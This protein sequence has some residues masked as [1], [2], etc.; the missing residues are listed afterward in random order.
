MEYLQFDYTKCNKQTFDSY[1]DFVFS[2]K[3]YRYYLYD[4]LLAKCDNNVKGEDR[5]K[6]QN[7]FKVQKIFWLIPYVFVAGTFIFCFKNN[8]FHT[9]IIDREIRIFFRAFTCIMLMRGLQKAHL[10]YFGDSILPRLY[11][12]FH[13]A[14]QS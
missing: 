8:I 12:E 13:Q 1:F 9:N 3:T 11:Q 4:L 6:I 5:Q 7:F 2:R 10:K 14:A